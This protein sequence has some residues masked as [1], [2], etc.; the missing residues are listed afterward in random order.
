MHASAGGSLRQQVLLDQAYRLRAQAIYQV[1]GRHDRFVALRQHF[2]LVQA[3]PQ[4]R[5]GGQQADAARM[6]ALAPQ[7]VQHRL[8]DMQDGHARRLRQLRIPDVSGIAGDGDR[9]GAGLLQPPY[10]VA[11]PRQ[12]I[13]ALSGLPSGPVRHARVVPQDGRYMLLVAGGFGQR[14]QPLHET[15]AGHRP[16]AAQHAQE[17]A[18]EL[19]VVVARH[20]GQWEMILDRKCRA[21]GER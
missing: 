17:A 2:M 14:H 1:D 21:R 10:A 16:H 8:H 9:G 11:H 6:D 4:R 18:L 7:V 15:G 3:Q 5:G 19:L 12:R 13:G 20:G